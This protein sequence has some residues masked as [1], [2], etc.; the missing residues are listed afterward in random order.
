MVWFLN[1][2]LKTGLNKPEYSLCESQS[3]IAITNEGGYIVDLDISHTVDI[4]ILKLSAYYYLMYLLC[5]IAC[6]AFE[7]VLVLQ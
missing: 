2:G 7:Y 5:I 3:T 6:Y 1:G 4:Q